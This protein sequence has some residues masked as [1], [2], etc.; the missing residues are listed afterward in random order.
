LAPIYGTYAV[1]AEGAKIPADAPPLFVATADDDPFKFAA[2]SEALQHLWAADKKPA[3]LNIYPTAGH[4]FGMRK[5]YQ[6]SDAWANRF[7]DW[8][9]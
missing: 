1:A 4:G 2:M 5:Q 8:R 6:P 7:A 9:S 3:E